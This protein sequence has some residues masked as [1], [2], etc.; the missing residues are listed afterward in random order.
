MGVFILGGTL[1]NIAIGNGEFD[2]NLDEIRDIRIFIPI[3]NIVHVANAHVKTTGFANDDE[4]DSISLDIDVNEEEEIVTLSLSG[5]R[6]VDGE[7]IGS[8]CINGGAY[9]VMI[10]NQIKL[11]YYAS[12]GS[13]VNGDNTGLGKAWVDVVDNDI[14]RHIPGPNGNDED[15]FAFLGGDGPNGDNPTSLSVWDSNIHN[16]PGGK[17]ME[18]SAELKAEGVLVKVYC[19]AGKI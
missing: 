12:A 11:Y 10:D 18:A 17:T 19:E 15:G 6:I 8:V 2:D 13:S 9:T 7:T 1:L 4:F 16:F 3:L 14:V 5:S